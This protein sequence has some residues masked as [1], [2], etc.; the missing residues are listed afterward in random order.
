MNIVQLEYIVE[1]AKTGSISIAAHNLNV[2]QPGVSQAITNMEKELGFKI[3]DRLRGHGAVPTNEGKQI[4][5]LSNEILFKFQELK[6]Q[7][8]KFSSLDTGKLKIGTVSGFMPNILN[9]LSTYKNIFPKVEVELLEKDASE[10]LDLV[11]QKKLDLGLV[12]FPSNLVNS[13]ENLKIDI[14]LQ[15]KM[16]VYVSKNSPLAFNKTVSPAELLKQNFVIHDS[17]FMRD[18]IQSNFHQYD[19]IHILFA[20]N[21]TEIINQSVR[22]NLAISFA[23]EFSRKNNPLVLNKEIIPIELINFG[24]IDVSLGWARLENKETTLFAKKF[25]NLVNLEF[26]QNY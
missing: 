17:Y 13:R 4:I 18:F 9:A 10:I 7:S 11:Q 2:T 16:K 8:Q 24:P 12:A 25:I 3:F 6:E 5:K 22:Q 15:S 26:Q 19:P 20:S 21:N 14:L 1:V 23:P